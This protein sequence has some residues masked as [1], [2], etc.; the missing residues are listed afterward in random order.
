VYVFSSA[1]KVTTGTTIEEDGKQ[2]STGDYSQKYPIEV[3]VDPM[4]QE[5]VQC[6]QYPFAPLIERGHL[7]SIVRC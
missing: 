1:S 4:Q 2:L 3:S 5:V 7:L 6:I